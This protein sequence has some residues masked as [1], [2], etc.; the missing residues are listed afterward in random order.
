MPATLATIPTKCEHPF[1]FGYFPVSTR[2]LRASLRDKHDVP[3]YDSHIVRAVR[4]AKLWR[5]ERM[6]HRYAHMLGRLEQ[7]AKTGSESAFVKALQTVSWTDRP[8]SDFTRAIRLAL[9]A[10]AHFAAREISEKAIRSYPSDAELQRL[11][12]ALAPPRLI[13]SALP[14][15]DVGSAN[16]KWLQSHVGEHKGRWVAVKNGELLGVAD[17]LPELTASLRDTADV[18]LTIAP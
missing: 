10:G 1:G 11:V 16:R 3:R 15:D 12:R 4:I 5:I 17:S 14:A 8:A 9:Q 7:A 18:L 2:N 13:S 6:R